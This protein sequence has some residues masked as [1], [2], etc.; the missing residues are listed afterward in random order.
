MASTRELD[1]VYMGIAHEVSILSK[2]N[3]KKVGAVIVKDNNIL[4]FGYN[5]TPSGMC[6]DCEEN[7]TTKWYVL[8]AESNAILKI[9]KSTLSSEGSTLYCTLSPCD[10]CCKLI[11]QSGITR[12][13]YEDVYEK[14]TK[15]LDLMIEHGIEVASL[16][17]NTAWS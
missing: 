16:Y 9:A 10:E 5:G 8:H 7:N 15:G 17:K 13:I 1:S 2:C 6:N 4:S 12:V 14:S 3:R 11:M